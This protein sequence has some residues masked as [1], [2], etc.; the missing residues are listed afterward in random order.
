LSKNQ[1]ARQAAAVKINAELPPYK[2]T[3]EGGPTW[4]EFKRG[5]DPEQVAL[6][7]SVDTCLGGHCVAGVGHNAY[8]YLGYVPQRDLVT[9]KK[10]HP[11]LPDVSSYTRSV[12]SGE[13]RIYSLRGPK[14]EVYATIEAKVPNLNALQFQEADPHNPVFTR[15]P[16]PSNMILGNSVPSGQYQSMLA[17]WSEKIASTPEFKAWARQQPLAIEQIKGPLNEAVPRE[18]WPYVQEFVRGNKWTEVLD[19]ENAGLYSVRGGEFGDAG[20]LLTEQEL[21]EA[22]RKYS[23]YRES[24][25]N[26]WN[27]SEL[28]MRL[29]ALQQGRREE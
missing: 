23:V 24:T 25:L 9:R 6:G 1:E 22:L 21:R 27:A 20:V 2:T 18:A 26:S 29:E 12:L 15:F 4:Y 19:A 13:T 3:V 28:R 16:E 14:G 8:G 7:L 5:M 17:A 11:N 10:V